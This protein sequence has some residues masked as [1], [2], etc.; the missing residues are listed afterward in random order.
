MCSFR[1]V[2]FSACALS[3]M[4]SFWHVLFLALSLF[5][6]CSFRHELF[7]ACALFWMCSFWHV[8]FLECDRSGMWWKWTVTQNEIC[9]FW[10]WTKWNVLILFEGWVKDLSLRHTIVQAEEHNLADVFHLNHL[11]C[12]ISNTWKN[13]K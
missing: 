5:G 12:F 2:H 13:G 1:H 10:M 7:S 8:L 4:W 6:M 3:S 11:L 9:L